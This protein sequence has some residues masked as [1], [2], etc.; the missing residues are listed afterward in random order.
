MPIGTRR[1]SVRCTMSLRSRGHE[2]WRRDWPSP[3]RSPRP[4]RP[5]RRGGSMRLETHYGKAEVSTYR[6]AGT[7][8]TGVPAIPESS[9]TG[10][11]NA[12]LAAEIDVQVLGEAVVA[13]YTQGD[14]SM[15]VATD[16]MKNFIHRESPAFEGSTLEGWLFFLGRRF[17]E[18]YTQMERLRVS[19][20]EIRFDAARV[21]LDG[22]GFGESRVL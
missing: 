6:T 17:L 11:A 13:A 16:T 5:S 15:V 4:H 22:G 10:R 21:P 1:S 3:A 12:V 20:E 7:A 8:L 18:T 14:N 19:G 9:F 2:P